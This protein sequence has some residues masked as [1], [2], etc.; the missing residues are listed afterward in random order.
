M[1]S[2]ADKQGSADPQCWC[3]GSQYPETDLVRLG[4]HPEVGI[5]LECAHWLRRRATARHDEQHHTLAGQLRGV[6]QATR[7]YVINRGWHQYGHVGALLR[8][9]NRHLP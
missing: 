4:Q 5:C 7:D 8:R 1:T 6:L 2:E 9:I 3:C